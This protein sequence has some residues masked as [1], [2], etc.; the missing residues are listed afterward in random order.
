MNVKMMTM[1]GALVTLGGIA[2]AELT[3]TQTGSTRASHKTFVFIGGTPVYNPGAEY[4]SDGFDSLMTEQVQSFSFSSAVDLSAYPQLNN[5]TEDY[6]VRTQAS[7]DRFEYS[8][9]GV[10]QMGA[11]SPLLITDRVQTSMSLQASL[12]L[13]VTEDTRLRFTWEGSAGHVLAPDIEIDSVNEVQIKVSSLSGT[14]AEF[15]AGIGSDHNTIAGSFSFEIDVLAGEEIYVDIAN[16]F[17]NTSIGNTSTANG[18]DQFQNSS[19]VIEVVPA[20][21]V[22]SLFGIGGLCCTRRR[23]A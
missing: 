23:R 11:N 18:W 13:G 22:A 15:N 4:W 12:T 8:W 19:F 20:P 14:I 5:L 9:S 2:Q 1:I 6:S 10:A 21:G 16:I 7:S 17:L 3:Y